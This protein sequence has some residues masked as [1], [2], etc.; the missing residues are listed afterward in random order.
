MI[1][2]DLCV[3][4][5]KDRECTLGLKTPTGMRCRE[6]YPGIERFCSNPDDFVGSKQV[7]EMATFFGVKGAELKKVKLMATREESVRV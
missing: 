5:G 2:C 1:A 4:L 6:F 7:L 3:Y